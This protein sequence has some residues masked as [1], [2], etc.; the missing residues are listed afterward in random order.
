MSDAPLKL[1][2][3]FLR[4]KRAE[5]Y[6]GTVE[7]TFQDGEVKHIRETSTMPIAAYAS[8][9]WHELPEEDREE[10]KDKFRDVSSFKIPS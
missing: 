4:R 7:L 2:E 5:G 3:L 9:V 10:L 8:E 6:Y 1:M